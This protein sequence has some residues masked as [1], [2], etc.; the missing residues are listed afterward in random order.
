MLKQVLWFYC[1]CLTNNAQTSPF[2]LW[3]L[4]DKQCL[5]IF[6]GKKIS[7]KNIVGKSC[8]WKIIFCQKKN[9]LK[10]LISLKNNF[11][12]NKEFLWGKK[13]LWK[14]IVRQNILFKKQ[15]FFKNKF[16][17]KK[18]FLP[19]KNF[20][21]VKNF[22]SKILL[23]YIVFLWKKNLSEKFFCWKKNFLCWKKNPRQCSKST[24]QNK[25]QKS[26]Y[27]TKSKAKSKNQNPRKVQNQNPRLSPKIK[28]QD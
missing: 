13:F 1:Y 17:W 20:C 6:A 8:L 16:L 10:K 9:L 28:I 5:N 27:K 26:K 22:L 15:F 19:E 12:L 4:F 7:L 24:I 25:V 21:W 3:L 11:S 23:E 14:K 18:K 2:L